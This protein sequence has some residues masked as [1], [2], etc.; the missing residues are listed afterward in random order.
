M[1]A[2][3][4]FHFLLF[5][6]F[7]N[8]F[9]VILFAHSRTTA[10]HHHGLPFS[11]FHL[12]ATFIYLPRL[13]C[14]PTTACPAPPT[15]T[16]HHLPA[17]FLLYRVLL[18]LRGFAFCT[19]TA[20]AFR[21]ART[22]A[23]GGAFH[24]APFAAR[25]VCARFYFCA[26][27]LTLFALY[28]FT[29]RFGSSFAFAFSCLCM[30]RLLLALCP[31]LPLPLPLPAFGLPRSSFAAAARTLPLLHF[32]LPRAPPPTTH[33]YPTCLAFAVR[34]PFRV[35]FTAPLRA[36]AARA[37][38]RAFACRRRPRV[39]HTCPPLPRFRARAHTLPH[40]APHLAFIVVGSQLR[41]R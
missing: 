36:F 38:C 8:T 24:R 25:H 28:T 3:C 33:A 40:T 32:T 9:Y 4:L 6:T 7:Y 15:T 20:R 35:W 37:H 34:V 5:H 41:V 12:F 30:V 13:L 27:I 39:L 22:R 29:L 23:G 26:R 10:H 11:T 14:L 31:P 1:R 16:F 21:G 2:F 17:P 19:H 18:H